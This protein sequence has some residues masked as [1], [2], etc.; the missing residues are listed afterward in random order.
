[1]TSINESIHQIEFKNFD[2]EKKQTIMNDNIIYL[3]ESTSLALQNIDSRFQDTLNIVNADIANVNKSL[4]VALESG[5]STSKDRVINETMALLHALNGSWV[6]LL[7][8]DINIAKQDIRE[9]INKSTTHTHDRINSI[10]EDVIKVAS[11]FNQSFHQLSEN[12]SRELNNLV[13]KSKLDVEVLRQDIH[14]ANETSARAIAA[15]EMTE[16]SLINVSN[17]LQ[18]MR[19]LWEKESDTIQHRINLT[20]NAAADAYFL[21]NEKIDHLEEEI[22]S[23]TNASMTSLSL[24]LSAVATNTSQALRED[25]EL[26][27]LEM[28]VLTNNLEE[29]IANISS[30][31]TLH[32]TMTN[33]SL[34]SFSMSLKEELNA[35]RKEVDNAKLNFT[36]TTEL[37]QSKFD[38]Y[39]NKSHY[40]SL[41]REALL[42]AATEGKLIG[43][44]EAVEVQIALAEEATKRKL[45]ELEVRVDAA[46]DDLKGL[47][48]LLSALQIEHASIASSHNLALSRISSMEADVKSLTQTLT[49]SALNLFSNATSFLMTHHTHTSPP[50]P[51]SPHPPNICDNVSEE[52][53]RQIVEEML[54]KKGK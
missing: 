13:E 7:E 44:A 52:R 50:P 6:T 20:A 33:A 30:A 26:H 42:T 49:H 16:Q 3:N 4:L 36:H 29:R 12:T 46:V 27:K 51:P 31:L 39:L 41:E 53:V 9:E 34:Q 23:E 5:L 25:R 40:L 11:S 37:L 35:H 32:S 1:M 2:Y 10:S 21:I 14:E 45:R 38:D 15:I 19:L 47:A 22:R 17:S 43:H 8:S 24:S 54:T 28:G 48:K 18:N